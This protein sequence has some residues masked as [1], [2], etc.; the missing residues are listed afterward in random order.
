MRILLAED[1]LTLNSIISERL[2]KEGYAVD[3]TR[4]G[5]EALSYLVA[6]TY[7][8]IILD[9]MMPKVDG[10]KVLQTIRQ[11]GIET[12]VIMLTARDQITDKIKGLDLGADDYMVKPFSYDEL[13]ARIRSVLRRQ[14]K[15]IQTLLQIEGLT[16]NRTTNEVVRNG[17][18]IKLSRKEYALL[19]Y[20]MLH[21][22]EVVSR[23][24]LERVSTN[25]D[26]EGYSNVIDVYIR[27]LRKKVDDPF[28]TKL[29]Q[30]VRGFG[31]TIKEVK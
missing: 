25:F 9:I 24:N 4:D 16:L 20:L 29:I 19:E 21:E 6:T 10:L 28:P 12:P 18:D 2:V 23:E 8:V 27:F 7:N 1:Q 30:T 5:E 13:V 26:Y 17:V 22:G 3:A 15:T 14:K 11:K 31:Y